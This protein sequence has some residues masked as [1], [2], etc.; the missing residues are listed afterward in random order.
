M[1]D[2]EPPKMTLTCR[3]PWSSAGEM[4]TQIRNFIANLIVGKS[5]FY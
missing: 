5:N 4:V 2:N 3:T 1:F